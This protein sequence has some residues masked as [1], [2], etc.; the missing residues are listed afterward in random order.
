ML[1]YTNVPELSKI[2]I[3]FQ[4]TKF[5][6]THTS[7]H[8]S[9]DIKTEGLHIHTAIEFVVTYSNELDFL[10]KGT[11]HSL[12]EGDAILSMPSD[13]HHAIFKAEKTYEFFCVWIET[14]SNSPLISFLNNYKNSRITF[15]AEDAKRN[16][17]NL[18]IASNPN[19]HPL[20][21]TAAMLNFL[22]TVK[23][24][25]TSTLS[26]NSHPVYLKKIINDINN[27]SHEILKV[28]DILQRHHV[29]Q[30][31]LNRWFKIYLNTSP[32]LYLE[33]EK[34]AAATKMLINGT[35]VT[36]ACFSSGFS[37]CSHFIAVFKKKFKKTPL[38]YKKDNGFTKIF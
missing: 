11:I 32:R 30:A 25:G 27:N 15:S 12:E 21:K 23:N 13:L 8:F 24:N 29:S 4:N 6:V 35:S 38:S 1:N 22:T 28:S 2:P 19:A 16:Y 5:A 33:N 7:K 10:V 37:D 9:L 18:T 20:D 26:N 34:L 36:E 14:D 17:D 31:T 3:S